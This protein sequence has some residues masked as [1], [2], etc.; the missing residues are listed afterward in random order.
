MTTPPPP[1]P[2][3]KTNPLGAALSAF[4]ITALLFTILP[5]TQMVDGEPDITPVCC[6]EGGAKD[7]PP[8][9]PPPP[10]D[11]DVVEEDEEPPELKND[12]IM[13]TIEGMENTFEYTLDG[14]G[15]GP[16]KYDPGNS[17]IDDDMVFPYDAL[18]EVPKPISRVTPAYVN[19]GATAKVIVVFVVDERGRVQQAQIESSTNNSFNGPVLEAIKKWTFTPG[20]KDGRK[21]KTMMRQPFSFGAN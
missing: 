8:P 10:V 17:V 20:I 6:T 16:A 7:P 21:V 2:E 3:I 12:R 5:L 4:G 13:P 1:T 15:W 14:T 9:P 11:D 18:T 19:R